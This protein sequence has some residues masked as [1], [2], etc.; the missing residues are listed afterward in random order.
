[1][2]FFVQSVLYKH[3]ITTK[4]RSVCVTTVSWT[5]VGNYCCGYETVSGGNKPQYML[6]LFQQKCSSHIS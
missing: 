5:D 3:H 4:D 6:V 2:P 1:M